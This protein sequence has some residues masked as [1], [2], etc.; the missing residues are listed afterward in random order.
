MKDGICPKCAATEVYSHLPKATN[1]SESITIT[2]SFINRGAMPEKFL[3]LACGYLEYYLPLDEK[4]RE[5]VTTT[6]AKV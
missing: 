4:I 2:D 1:P 6:W 5:A 3:C